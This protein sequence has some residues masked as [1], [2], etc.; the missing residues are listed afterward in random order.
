MDILTVGENVHWIKIFFQLDVDCESFLSFLLIFRPFFMLIFT[1][2]QKYWTKK[3][4]M[5][6]ITEDDFDGYQS[7]RF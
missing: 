3:V 7:S 2:T 6:E 4:S 1:A 5:V